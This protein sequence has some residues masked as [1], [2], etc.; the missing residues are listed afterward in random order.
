METNPICRVCK[1]VLTS[2]NW[3]PAR[4]KMGRY[5][6]KK[7]EM[8]YNISWRKNNPEKY[9]AMNTRNSRKRGHLPMNENKECTLYLGIYIGEQILGRV[10]KNVVRMPYGNPGYDF[11]CNNDKLID[12]K[13]SCMRKSYNGWSFTIKHNTTADHFLCVAFDNRQDLNPMYIW[14]IPG[15]ILNHL[16]QASISESTLDK[17]D[18]YKQPI[19]G[20]IL[21]CDT[22]KGGEL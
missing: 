21:C 18:E 6:C 13:I 3:Y 9:K 5:I 15:H 4:Q 1:E 12:V 17:W 19:D 2:E 11:I 14:L 22:M 16:M 10:F 8:E 7:C 20:V